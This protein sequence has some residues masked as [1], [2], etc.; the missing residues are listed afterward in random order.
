MSQLIL[1]LVQRPRR[2]ILA[3]PGTPEPLR[4]DA[5]PPAHSSR[6]QGRGS[7]GARAGFVLLIVDD[8]PLMT[9]M[10]PRRM[11]KVLRA[12]VEIRTAASADEAM[13][14]IRAIQPDVVL[15]DYNLRQLRT[16]LDVL[17]EA[18]TSAPRAARILFSG[19]A[20]GEI[21]GLAGASI[22]A[23]LEKPMQLDELIPPVL[24]AIRRATGQDLRGG[25]PVA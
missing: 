14:I 20:P 25:A 18:E 7:A 6:E 9:D 2:R 13:D 21:I 19:H 23:Y 11:R 22:H 10:L 17:R 24:E 8:D 1:P 5:E 16:G 4:G 15:C 12:D 3:S